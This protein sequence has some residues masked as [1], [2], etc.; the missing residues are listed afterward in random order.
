MTQPYAPANVPY[1]SLL[2]YCAMERGAFQAG[3]PCR[4][5]VTLRN[6]TR[7]RYQHGLRTGP[8]N[9]VVAVLERVAFL[10]P[11]GECS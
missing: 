10:K 9:S 5:E 7:S 11:F 6:A 2:E 8:D 1:R 4:P 3:G